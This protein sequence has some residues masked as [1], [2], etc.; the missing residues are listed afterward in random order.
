MRNALLHRQ[1][2]SGVTMRDFSDEELDVMAEAYSSLLE[3]MPHEFTPAEIKLRLVE[4][5][6]AG[7]ANGLR[8]ED[9]LAEA[10]LARLSVGELQ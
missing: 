3:R 1:N 8:D 9:A 7:V 5:I 2:G 6:G 4:E 10:A